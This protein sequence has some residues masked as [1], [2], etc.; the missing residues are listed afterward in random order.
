MTLVVTRLA[1]CPEIGQPTR[2][3]LQGADQDA[4]DQDEA[5]RLKRKRKERNI[6]T[7]PH[8]T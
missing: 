7:T 6:I 5:G 2:G 3:S 8:G 4:H 1:H